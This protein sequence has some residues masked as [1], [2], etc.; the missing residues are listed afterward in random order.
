MPTR[1]KVR[2]LLALPFL[3]LSF[4][5]GWGL[6]LAGAKKSHSQSIRISKKC[7]TVDVK[8]GLLMPEEQ[9]TH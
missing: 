6:Y 7:R 3:L 2:A 1:S 9:I 4:M 5:L 8:V